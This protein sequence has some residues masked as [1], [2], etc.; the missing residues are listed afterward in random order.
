MTEQGKL[1]NGDTIDYAAGLIIEDNKGLP[2]IRHGGAFVGFRA[3]LLRFPHERLSIAIFAN[4]G[5]ANP[6]K[7]ADQVADIL[8]IDELVESRELSDENTLIEKPTE[9]YAL[10]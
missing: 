3:E 2:T 10:S 9:I 7:L 5:Y 6:S 8:L 4:S 1:N